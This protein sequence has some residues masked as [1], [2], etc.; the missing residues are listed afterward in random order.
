MCVSAIQTSTGTKKRPEREGEKNERKKRRKNCLTNPNTSIGKIHWE[1]FLSPLHLLFLHPMDGCTPFGPL[2][3]V[4]CNE[5]HVTKSIPPSS[6]PNPL[7]SYSVKG[8]HYI[9]S[10]S[11]THIP[12]VSCNACPVTLLLNHKQSV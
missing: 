2:N 4:N 3:P 6:F 7:H 1:Q 10:L 12:F 11:H 5:R 8:V 9:L